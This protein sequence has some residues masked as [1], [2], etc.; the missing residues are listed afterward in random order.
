M[1]VVT[2]KSREVE[3]YF[4]QQ[5]NIDEDCTLKYMYEPSLRAKEF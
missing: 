2:E 5:I 3:K 4:V 1:R